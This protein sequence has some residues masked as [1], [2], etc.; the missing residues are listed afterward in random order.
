MH[1]LIGIIGAIAAA[2][3]AFRYFVDAAHEGREAVRDARGFFRRGKWTQKVG[4][5]L[6]ESLDDPRESAAVLLYQIAAYDGAVTDIQKKSII[7]AMKKAF[8]ADDETAEGLFAFSRM[9]VGELNDASNS[10]KKILRPVLEMCTRE[11]KLELVSMLGAIA[12]VEGAPSD[13][14][15]RMINEAERILL[16]D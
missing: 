7:A 10:M 5:R 4:Q 2:F 8:D 6:I 9:A 11:E 16:S 1:I 15:Q 14:Q 12:A 3:F 13:S